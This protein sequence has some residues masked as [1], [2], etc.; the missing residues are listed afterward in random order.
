MSSMQKRIVMKALI[1][2]QFNVKKRIFST[3]K[4]NYAN[5]SFFKARMAMKIVY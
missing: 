4:R 3:L 5:V 1:E 2:Y